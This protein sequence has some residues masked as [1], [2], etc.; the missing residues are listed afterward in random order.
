MC[1]AT[2]FLSAFLLFQVQPMLAKR[3]LP[4][5]GGVAGV[6][7][8]CLLFFQGALFLGYLYA[9]VIV[10]RLSPRAQFRTHVAT[11]AVSALFL[12]VI[13]SA[14]WKPSGQEEPILLILSL[15]VATIGLPFLLLS[16]TSPLVQSWYARVSSGALPYRYFA[17][18]NLAS[19]AALLTYPTL[20]E[21]YLPM[22]S[23]AILWSAA[24]ALYLVLAG[25]TAWGARNAAAAAAETPVA[26]ARPTNSMR[27]S[28]LALAFCASAISI[29]ATNHLCQN[30]AAIPLLWVVPLSAYL[31]TFILCFEREGWYP[32]KPMLAL[33]VAAM[34]GMGWL[35]SKQTPET[36]IRLI[37][38]AVSAGIFLCCM[39]CHGELVRRKPAHEHLTEFYLMISLGGVLGAIVVGLGAPYLLRGNH[40]FPFALAACAITILFLEYRRSALGD[41]LWASVAV[42]TLAVA[43]F[44]VQLSAVN[45]RVQARNFYGGLRS[46]D[47]DGYRILVHG[48]INHGQQVL[49]PQRR[50]HPTTYYARGTGV[51]L[52]IEALRKPA[53]R[54]G[55]IGLGAGTLAA[56]GKP[57]DYYRFYELN[58]Q[59]LHL[60]R[61]EFT[62]L[63]EA[64][65]NTEVILG[66]GRLSLERE[67]A[68]NFDVLVVDAFSGDSIPVHLLS[69]EAFELYLRHIRPGG[70]LALH[71]SS[72]ILRIPPVVERAV[73]SL[74]LH[75]LYIHNAPDPNVYRSEAEWMLVAR[76]PD[77][78]RRPPLENARPTQVAYAGVRL[79]TD[80]YS[81]LIP[82]LK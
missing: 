5:F 74:G 62:F 42:G 25:W 36:D 43:M 34:A 76:R 70:I 29:S 56:Y 55:I 33:F 73:Q 78:L 9:H 41:V 79:W 75:S 15:L 54:V 17:L 3:I 60:A 81:A 23:Q 47:R 71:I 51:E 45:A 11:L 28:W 6:W 7:S 72:Q 50:L 66:D 48:V 64:Q 40:E 82:I 26:S 38:A 57:G 32:R 1:G 37:I 39:V 46:V 69:R 44:Q 20:V 49:D 63:R 24:Y 16:S 21:P 53:Q 31:L 61:T 65:A 4:W 68:Q 58:P 67:T 13:P 12:P 80:D 8:T 19:L 18:S 77:D 10:K 30:V 2:I 52:A 35:I 27:V 59:V 14:A 22:Q